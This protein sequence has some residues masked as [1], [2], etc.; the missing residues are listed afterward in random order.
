MN[1]EQLALLIKQGDR[2]ALPLLW[3]K[4]RRLILKKAIR[5]HAKFENKRGLE[6]D[7]LV[8]NGYF[9]V[10]SAVKYYEPE[11]GYRFNTFL[12]HTLI[13]ALR[14]AAGIRTS[15]RD[16]LDYADSL[17]EPLTGNDGGESIT[18]IGDFIPD[19]VAQT[20]F[21]TLLIE[22]IAQAILDEAKKLP[23][24]LH[25]RI[26]YECTYQGRTLEALANE[27]GVS[28]QNISNMQ[29]EAI[30]RLRRRP[31]IR[32]IRA[33]FFRECGAAV[34]ESLLDPYKAKGATAFGSDFSSI[35]DDIVLR[36]VEA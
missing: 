30:W 23:N 20:A 18:Q 4:T 27:L 26:I 28:H 15:K 34:R 12:H 9:A 22:D 17:D 3:E 2:S 16:A 13:S 10:L 19:E 14:S 35:V 11:K 24:P 8:Q 21:E 29:E 5:Y 32:A 33:E 31:V 25:A 36:R 6:V 1:N 7:D